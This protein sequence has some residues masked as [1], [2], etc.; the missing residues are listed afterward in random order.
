MLTQIHRKKKNVFIAYVLCRQCESAFIP[1]TAQLAKVV[2]HF[3]VP[4]CIQLGYIHIIPSLFRISVQRNK[5]GE[6]EC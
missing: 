1:H 2:V 5:R 3:T 4:L 6:C